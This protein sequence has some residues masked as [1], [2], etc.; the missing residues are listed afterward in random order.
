LQTL[1]G[2]IKVAKKSPPAPEKVI[3]TTG[4]SAASNATLKKLEEEADRT[5]DRSK[6]V[7]YKRNLKKG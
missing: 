6:V 3:N 5:G 1:Q 2:E 4:S 7:Q